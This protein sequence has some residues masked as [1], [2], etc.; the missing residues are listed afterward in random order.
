MI[1]LNPT[2]R[3]RASLAVEQ[4]RANLTISV[5]SSPP[6]NHTWR[7]PAWLRLPWRRIHSWVIS[8]SRTCWNTGPLFNLLHH[9]IGIWMGPPEKLLPDPPGPTAVRSKSYEVPASKVWIQNVFQSA[10]ANHDLIHFFSMLRWSLRPKLS[11]VSAIV[12]KSVEPLLESLIQ[13]ELDL[14][15]QSPP[16]LKDRSGTKW[17]M[18]SSQ[19]M[20]SPSN[21]TL[22]RIP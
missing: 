12:Q 21:L 20:T 14:A 19:G 22:S 10:E 9:I 8:R 2:F 16:H 3:S 13:L 15:H 11:A 1:Q 17:E 18:P 4:Q 7:S 5:V 6:R